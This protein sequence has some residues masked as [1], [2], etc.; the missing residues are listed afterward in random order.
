MSQHHGRLSGSARQ[1]R[2]TKILA[3]SD[4]CGI[5]GQPG[6]DAIDH[7]T[8][9]ARG[10]TEHHSNLQPVH[11]D[12]APF[13][14][15]RKGDLLP[16]EYDRK[17][18]LIVGPPG[19]GKTT[20]AHALADAEGLEV[21]DLDDER[22]AGS[23]ALFRAALIQLREQPKARA[24]VIRTGATLK[25]RQGAATACG[26][27]DLI[28]VDT[29]LDECVRRIKQR[30]R[31]SPPIRIQIHGARDWWTRYE[32]GTVKLS[33]ASLRLQRSGSLA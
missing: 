21:Y 9:L 3:A 29:P 17:V 18:V 7:K 24:V 19:A 26:A 5:C 6:S 32:P 33:F 11:H 13:C 23:N 4:I 31:T 30:G 25:A 14:N 16:S 22:W 10:G 28:V 15:R 1:R 27:T 20:L 12:V 2:N 8:P